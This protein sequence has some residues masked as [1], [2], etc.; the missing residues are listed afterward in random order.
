MVIYK[1]NIG[2]SGCI[3]SRKKVIFVLM[4][5]TTNYDLNNFYDNKLKVSL[6]KHDFICERA[7]KKEDQNLDRPIIEGINNADVIIADLTGRNFNV[8]YELAISDTLKKK[9]LMIRQDND[10]LPFDIQKYKVIRYDNNNFNLDNNEVIK[11]IYQLITLSVDRISNL[12]IDHLYTEN[13]ILSEQGIKLL[14]ESFKNEP[15]RIVFIDLDGTLFNSY[16]HRKG[17]SIKAFKNIFE[18]MSITEINRFYESIYDLHEDYERITK[19]NFRYDWATEDIYRIAYL[20]SKKLIPKNYDDYLKLCF[21]H[22]NSDTLRSIE[23]AHKDFINEIFNPLPYAHQFLEG[24]QRLGFGLTL[25]T[26]GIKEA[27]EW[28]LDG[29][30]MDKY[31]NDK[32]RY[33]GHPFEN[34]QK[35]QADYQRQKS[36]VKLDHKDYIDALNFIAEIYKD[37]HDK[38]KAFFHNRTVNTEIQRRSFPFQLAVMGDRYDVDLKPYELIN[39]K[40]IIRIAITQGS[41]KY[42]ESTEVSVKKLRKK[43]DNLYLV[44]TLYEA[45]KILA[46]PTKW[47][48]LKTITSDPNVEKPLLTAET[49]EKIKNARNIILNMNIKNDTFLT[50]VNEIIEYSQRGGNGKTLEEN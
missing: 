17:A 50:Y 20:Q 24:L 33:I 35:L 26:E 40:N 42:R 22:I 39:G 14:K 8:A 15:K 34:L 2:T 43:D 49:K 31:F 29:L 27:Q 38:C 28:K 16:N 44:E 46:D 41:P 18:N 4:P 37:M 48:K 45:F 7:D 11:G 25:V 10:Q 6:E 19:K 30:G 23:R 36:K 9:T 5:F 3:M 32:H 13:D 47:E 21:E 1:P 12:V